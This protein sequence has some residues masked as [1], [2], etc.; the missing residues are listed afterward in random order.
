[1]KILGLKLSR[2]RQWLHVLCLERR[3]IQPLHLL[4]ALISRR[5]PPSR[6]RARIRVCA[7]CPIYDRENRR[8]RMLV[9]RGNHITFLGCGCYVP[10]LAAFRQSYSR[11][12]CWGRVHI[13]ED[14]GWE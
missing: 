11:P 3:R 2:W 8:C 7:T 14:F 9:P 12:G 6:W 13:A 1:M 4:R 5:V 10:F